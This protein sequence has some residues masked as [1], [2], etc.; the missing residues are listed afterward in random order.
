MTY[1]ELLDGVELARARE[2]VELGKY[3]KVHYGNGMRHD[4]KLRPILDRERFLMHVLNPRFTGVGQATRAVAAYLTPG[5]ILLLAILFAIYASAAILCAAV[6]P[7]EIGGSYC[8]GGPIGDG[9]ELLAF[10]FQD[11]RPA[12]L[13]A[14]AGLLLSFY[15]S[16][17]MTEYKAAHLICQDAKAQVQDFVIFA[18]RAAVELSSPP[19]APTAEPQPLPTRRPIARDRLLVV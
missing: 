9:Q 8:N 16:A 1:E 4:S 15:A 3:L 18:V 13:N 10:S 11:Y 14:I 6:D 17:V 19:A 2:A 5:R 7:G 12:F